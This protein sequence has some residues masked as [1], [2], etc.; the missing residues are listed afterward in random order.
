MATDW[1]EHSVYLP[2]GTRREINAVTDDLVG[3]AVSRVAERLRDIRALY[4]GGSLARREPAV[5]SGWPPRLVSDIDVIA[6]LG[7][8]GRTDTASVLAAE[9]AVSGEITQAKVGLV[10]VAVD[11]VERASSFFAVDLSAAMRLPVRGSVNER[12]APLRLRRRDRIELI[13]HQ[14]SSVLLQSLSGAATRD[15]LLRPDAGYHTVKLPLEC[16]R[17]LL[18]EPNGDGCSYASVF[19]MRHDALCRS[20]LPASLVERLIR[21]RELF[22]ADRTR[23]PDGRGVVTRVLAAVFDTVPDTLVVVQRILDEVAALP[24]PLSV[25]QATCL[26]L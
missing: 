5:R 21:R 10:A 16:L 9:R 17:A 26:V 2:A 15:Y 18:A 23:L 7:A 14:V 4:V 22:G 13:V 6:V 12:K 8:D 25:Y 20:V 24:D 19:E 3:M 11:H 1:C